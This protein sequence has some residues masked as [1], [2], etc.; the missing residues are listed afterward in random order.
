MGDTE[1][2]TGGGQINEPMKTNMQVSP[3]MIITGVGLIIAVVFI[4]Q[5]TERVPMEFLWFDVE[6]PLWVIMVAMLLVGAAVGQA[7]VYMRA[8]RKRK[9]DAA[10]RDKKK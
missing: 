10:A 9:A 1:H 6:W 8:R 2:T 4:A 5:N 7:V 3:R